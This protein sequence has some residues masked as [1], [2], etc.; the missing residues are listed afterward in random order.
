M[1]RKSSQ[2]WRLKTRG[3]QAIFYLEIKKKSGSSINPDI[4]HSKVPS[5]ELKLQRQFSYCLFRYL[6]GTDFKKWNSGLLSDDASSSSS[7]IYVNKYIFLSFLS[8]IFNSGINIF[9]QDFRNCWKPIK[10]RTSAGEFLHP[11][12]Y[13]PLKPLNNYIWRE[14]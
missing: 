3:E 1:T 8:D 9:N 4:H 7:G 2:L 12:R 11:L 6:V 13:F 10:K 5:S 14:Y